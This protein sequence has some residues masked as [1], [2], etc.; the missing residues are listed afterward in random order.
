MVYF[1]LAT[2]NL[3]GAGDPLPRPTRY[4]GTGNGEEQSLVE[5]QPSIISKSPLA[6]LSTDAVNETNTLNVLLKGTSNQLTILVFK[7]HSWE[8]KKKVPTTSQ[9][10]A[11]GEAQLQNKTH[12]HLREK[13]FFLIG[14]V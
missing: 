1:Q 11:E 3:E 2:V 8:K 4:P 9:Q 7:T 14:P 10:T 12:K 13:A 5:S 6:A